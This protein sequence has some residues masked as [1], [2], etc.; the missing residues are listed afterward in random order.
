MEETKAIV[1]SSNNQF[2][3]TNGINIRKFT[4]Q[5]QILHHNEAYDTVPSLNVPTVSNPSYQHVT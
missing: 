2:K 1:T 5:Y 4:I 3:I